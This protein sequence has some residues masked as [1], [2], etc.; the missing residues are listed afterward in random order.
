MG[1]CNVMFQWHLEQGVYPV[2]GH[3]D[4]AAVHELDEEDGVLEGG[5]LQAD[6]ELALARVEVGAGGR[7]R[8]EEV[9]EIRRASGEHHLKS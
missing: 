6:D 5:V 3:V 1:H 7:E 2:L 4:L 9:L 8:Q